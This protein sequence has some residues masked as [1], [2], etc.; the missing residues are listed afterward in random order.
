MFCLPTKKIKS[1]NAKAFFSKGNPV[2][3][4]C[5]FVRVFATSGKLAGFCKGLVC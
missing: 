3:L 1:K 5:A 4:G 2:G